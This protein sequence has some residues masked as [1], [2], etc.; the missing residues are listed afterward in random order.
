MRRGRKPILVIQLP[1]AC[2]RGSN[3]V[4]GQ[5]EKALAEAE[6]AIELDPDFAIGYYNL[7]YTCISW[8]CRGSREHPPASRPSGL[9]IDEFIMLQIRHRLLERRPGGNGTGGGRA[10]RSGAETGSPTKRRLRWPMP[11]SCSR[12]G[13][14]HSA[15]WIRLSRRANGRGQVFGSGAAVRE[16]FSEIRPRQAERDGSTRALEGP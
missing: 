7:G 10:R 2:C 14:C 4:A 12:Q 9:E 3:K 8:P 1:T 16:A 13:G 6:K 15:R 5:Y 11:V